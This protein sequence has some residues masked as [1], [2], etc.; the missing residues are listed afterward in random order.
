M[1]WDDALERYIVEGDSFASKVN[2]LI[3]QLGA[4]EPPLKYH[5]N[6][7]RLAEYV[8][9]NL[10]WQIQKTGNR[11]VGEDYSSILEQGAFNDIDREELLRAAAGRIRAAIDRGQLHFD[12]ME[13][14][15]RKMLAD[16][17]AIILYHREDV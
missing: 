7:D 2:E 6:E 17:I 11:W 9:S 14:F 3:E 12:Q 8:K 5:D 4:V 13:W 16:V 15:H 10:K 1:T